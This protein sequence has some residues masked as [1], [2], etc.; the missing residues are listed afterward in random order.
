VRDYRLGV[1]LRKWTTSV[2][3]AFGLLCGVV[4]SLF[5]PGGIVLLAIFAGNQIWND[6][7]EKSR[8]KEYIRTGCT[9]WW[10]SFLVFCIV[11]TIAVILDLADAISIR[12]C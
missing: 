10:E 11:F 8:N 7:E 2:H 12:W 5:F 3:W 6:K 4:S 1:K 9:D